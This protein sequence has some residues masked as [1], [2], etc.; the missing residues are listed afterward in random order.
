MSS[1][2]TQISETV[3]CNP[4]EL[5][6]SSQIEHR[7]AQSDEAT[8]I[9][10]CCFSAGDIPPERSHV[11]RNRDYPTI[12]DTLPEVNLDPSIDMTTMGKITWDKCDA[13][14]S[15]CANPSF[16]YYDAATIPELV[17]SNWPLSQ[18]SYQ[19]SASVQ[20]YA[21]PPEG[22]EIPWQSGYSEPQDHGSTPI[23]HYPFSLA[24]TESKNVSIPHT[25][26]GSFGIVEDEQ[27]AYIPTT[28]RASS[29]GPDDTVGNSH[30]DLHN[31]GFTSPSTKETCTLICSRIG[32]ELPHKR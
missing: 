21:D 13:L 32:F 22:W 14:D 5:S 4:N 10:H 19:N 30:Y 20:G 15:D 26:N 1:S 28:N 7:S 17:S 29:T 2:S 24:T 8:R 6:L 23:P 16:L 12:V 27:K 25:I 3:F 18:L 9:S 31:C 11:C